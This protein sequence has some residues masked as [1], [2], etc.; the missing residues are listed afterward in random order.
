M[1]DA[2]SLTTYGHR[3]WKGR[4]GMGLGPPYFSEGTFPPNKK[5]EFC[6]IS[7]CNAICKNNYSY[8]YALVSAA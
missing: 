3:W 5:F 7:F 6:K 2:E 4:G 1:Y 8:V